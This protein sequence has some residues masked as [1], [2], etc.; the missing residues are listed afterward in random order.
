M[1]LCCRMYLILHQKI[2]CHAFASYS[3]IIHWWVS[4]TTFYKHTISFV[5]LLTYFD[6]IIS[7]GRIHDIWMISNLVFINIFQLRINIWKFS[8]LNI[9]YHSEILPYKTFCQSILHIIHILAWQYL[10]LKWWEKMVV[11]FC[12]SY[13]YSLLSFLIFQQFF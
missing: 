6:N 10:T 13:W 1:R 8:L 3:Y 5:T 7:V 2:H 4:V 9:I 11:S 12:V